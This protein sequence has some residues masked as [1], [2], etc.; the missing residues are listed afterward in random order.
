MNEDVSSVHKNKTS[1]ALQA[2]DVFWKLRYDM[3]LNAE[4]IRLTRR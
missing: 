4:W 2:E 3:E 1:S